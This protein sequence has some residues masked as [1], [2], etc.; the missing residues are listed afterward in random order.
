MVIEQP[1][2]AFFPMAGAGDQV[3]PRQRAHRAPAQ[4]APL[5]LERNPKRAMRH[6]FK[7]AKRRA[8]KKAGQRLSGQK[9]PKED[10]RQAEEKENARHTLHR[11]TKKLEKTYHLTLFFGKKQQFV[12]QTTAYHSV[13]NGFYAAMPKINSTGIANRARLRHPKAP[14]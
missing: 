5:R 6:S 13:Y 11:L 7:P 14:R 10:V 2:V 1:L 9:P 4:L 12:S 8:K 3:V